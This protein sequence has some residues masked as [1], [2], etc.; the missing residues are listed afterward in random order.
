MRKGEGGAFSRIQLRNYA[1]KDFF[2][3]TSLV[4]FYFKINGIYFIKNAISSKLHR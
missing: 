2:K 1:F 3:K 4:H